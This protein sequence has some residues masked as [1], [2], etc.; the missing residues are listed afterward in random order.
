MTIDFSSMIFY[1]LLFEHGEEP[2]M[3]VIAGDFNTVL[4]QRNYKFPKTFQNH[5]RCSKAI[6]EIIDDFDLL[7]IWRHTH[8]SE[9]K[10][11]WMSKDMKI[12]SR[13]DFCLISQ[14]LS[15]SVATSDITCGYRSDHSLVSLVLIKSITKRGPGF[16]KLNTS[17]LVDTNTVK[18][19]K[20]YIIF[21]MNENVNL[22]P[23]QCWEFLK[24]KIKQSLCK[25]QKKRKTKTRR[26]CK[27]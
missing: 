4:E 11:T 24:Y 10:Y 20:D 7:D 18:N 16:W 5:P 14:S 2:Y 27:M 22:D 8:L 13:I 6:M 21:I 17:L 9:K 1:S 19:I 23:F 15:S 25:F 3:Y 26:K 12:R